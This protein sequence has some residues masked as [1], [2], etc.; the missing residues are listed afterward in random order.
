MKLQEI[1]EGNILI[2]V[3]ILLITGM[4]FGG[5]AKK[6]HL[7]KITGYITAGILVGKPCFNLIDESNFKF[8]HIFNLVALGFMSIT[9][10]SYLDFYRLK[11]S[12]KRIAIILISEIAVSFLFIFLCIYFLIKEDILFSV[13]VATLSMATA[14]ATTIAII[15]ETRS[16]GALVNTLMPLVALNN[17]LCILCF[18]FV[19]NLIKFNVDAQIHFLQFLSSLIRELGYDLIIGILGGLLLVYYSRHHIGEKEKIL[20]ALFLLVFLFTGISM[21][22]N[23]NPML[24][25]LLAGMVVTNFCIHRGKVLNVF[26]E[27]EH[28]IFIL[29]FA[30]AGAHLD[31]SSFKLTGLAGFIYFLARAVGKIKGAYIAGKFIG[32][33]E[34]I[35]KNIGLTLL[36]QAGVVIGLVIMAGELDVL[37]PQISF[38]T[39]L[40]LAAVTLNELIGPPLA[41]FALKRSGELGENRP[42]L[43]DFFHEEFILLNI[44]G[45]NKVEVLKQLVEF[46]SKTHKLTEMEKDEL[47]SSVLERENIGSTGIGNGIAVPHG[48]ISRGANISGVVGICPK[49]VNFDSIDEQPVKLIVLVVTPRDHKKDMHLKVL[50]EVSKLLSDP[51]L[52]D[53]MFSAKNALEI[54]ELI[55]EKEKKEFNVFLDN[56]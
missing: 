32:L 23:I 24:P 8:L 49:G 51:D 15:K 12:I 54:C 3:S 20:T 56:T 42:K 43:V 47:L 33:P 6:L 44:S 21:Y 40:I 18:G 48:L 2:T 52:R 9:I 13:L 53:A 31:L 22:F 38:L 36:P 26:Q 16:K 30:L 7:P 4:I 11:N 37:H 45:K 10:G 34:R 17:A 14:P 5:V 19:I 35:Y 27:L 28:M 39:A 50:S 1:L 41:K 55:R 29:F 46:Y 25:C